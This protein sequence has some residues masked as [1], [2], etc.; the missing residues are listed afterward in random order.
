MRYTT[1]TSRAADLGYVTVADGTNA[2]DASEYRPGLAAA[3]DLDIYMPLLEAG[4]SKKDTRSIASLLGLPCADRPANACL[5]TRIP[6]GQPLHPER[7]KMIDHAETEIRSL[8]G[9]SMVRLRDHG[10]LARIEVRT[11]EMHR[12]ADAEVMKQ[13]SYFLR[14]LGFAFVT[15]DLEGYRSGSFDQ[16]QSQSH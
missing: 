14:D 9:V 10:N 7:L 4:L 1:L 15:L 11:E 12:L 8:T 2:S 3:K 13:I 6:Y 5:A 16:A